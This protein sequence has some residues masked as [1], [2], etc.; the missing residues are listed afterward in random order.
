M[1]LRRRRIVACRSSSRRRPFLSPCIL[2]LL[3]QIHP[4]LS[5]T[6][7]AMAILSDIVLDLLSRLARCAADL[8]GNGSAR[9]LK[10]RD[11]MSAFRLELPPTLAKFAISEAT[12]AITVYSSA[13]RSAPMAAASAFGFS[14]NNNNANHQ[15]N[16]ISIKNGNLLKLIQ[17]EFKCYLKY[18]NIYFIQKQLFLFVL[19]F[20]F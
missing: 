6:I 10:P 3:K 1:V 19:F 15:N 14:T 12:K 13:A 2:R 5:L 8:V 9:T 17:F 20:F 11:L 16:N 7:R 18:I 4:E